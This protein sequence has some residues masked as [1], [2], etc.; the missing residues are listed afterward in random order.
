VHQVYATDATARSVFETRN[1]HAAFL[2]LVALPA[3]AYFL[4]GWRAPAVSRGQRAF[5]GATL[6]ILFFSVFLTAGRGASLSLLISFLLLLALAWRHVE[7]SALLTLFGLLVGAFLATQISHGG[8]GARL[9]SFTQDVQRVLI[10]Q[11]TWE[12]IKDHPWLGVG[13]GLFFLAYPPYRQPA[14]A[15]GGFFAHNDYLQ[16]WAETGLPGLI[17]A[18]CALLSV[19]WLMARAWRASGLAGAARVELAGLFAGL[20]AI[21]AHSLVD[22]NFYILSILMVAGLVLGRWH[23]RIGEALPVAHW[24]ASVARWLTPR[25]YPANVLMLSAVGFIYFVSV[26]LTN[27]LYERALTQARQGDIESASRTLSTAAALNPRDDRAPVTHA[28]L[29]R[30]VL[31]L[32]IVKNE[33]DRRALF[34]DALQYLDEAA[35]ANPLRSLP[36]LL[37]ARLYREQSALAGPQWSARALDAYQRA[38]DLNPMMYVARVERA[39]LLLALNRLDEARATLE[40]GIDYRYPEE[41]EM[42]SFYRL[43][44]STWRK[45][46]EV[47]RAAVLEARIARIEDRERHTF[48]PQ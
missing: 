35:A 23:E 8:L 32:K 19:A 13:L 11:S 5:L 47:A 2:N 15:S 42:L 6:F 17:L 24:Q 1:T 34:D 39:Q 18:V 21:A 43:T 3:S 48:L 30:H 14:D 28:D 27:S 44:A 29:Y 20:F 45:T 25:T 9:P 22:F 26:G 4:L 33:Q 31:R 37:R 36:H 40:A 16:F 12:M 41:T 46:G 7:R 10:W 38:L